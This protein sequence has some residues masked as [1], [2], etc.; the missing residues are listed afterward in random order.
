[1]SRRGR[2]PRLATLHHPHPADCEGTQ[3]SRQGATSNRMEPLLPATRSSQAGQGHTAGTAGDQRPGGGQEFMRIGTPAPAAQTPRPREKLNRV[4]G[5][6]WKQETRRAPPLDIYFS[7]CTAQELTKLP[8]HPSA[9]RAFLLRQNRRP[10]RRERL[11]RLHARGGGR[12][13]LG[14]LADG[15]HGRGRP[16]PRSGS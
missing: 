8:E 7:R 5:A 15:G 10:A 14:S 12:A 1:M 3:S 11:L 9:S 6:A 2:G 4:R 13:R 16:L